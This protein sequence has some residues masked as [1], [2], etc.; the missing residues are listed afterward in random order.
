MERD[1]SRPPTRTISHDG[2][3]TLS[4]TATDA[5]GH[6]SPVATHSFVVAATTPKLTYNVV[7]TDDVVNLSEAANAA[8]VLLTGGSTGLAVGAK[9]NVKL[10][11][12]ATSDDLMAVVAAGGAWT[13]TLSSAQAKAL[14]DGLATLTATAT[15]A[16]GNVS[17]VATH[18]VRI[19]ETPPS[20]T[21]DTVAGDNSLSADEAKKGFAITGTSK[22]LATGATFAVK[23][24]ENGVTHSYNAVVGAN[25][26]WSTNV[27]SA[28]ARALTQ[29][30]AAITAQ[31]M[32]IYGNMSA[33]AMRSISISGG[34]A[35]GDVHL[36][37]F[38]G[39]KYDFQATGE[40][41]LVASTNPLR[42]FEVQVQEL[43]WGNL[44]SVTTEVGVR[45][46]DDALVFHL[47]GSVSIDGLS[48]AQSGQLAGGPI[49]SCRRA[50]TKSIGARASG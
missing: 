4:A 30:S 49:R 40:F 36:T 50:N 39:V 22:G 31:A 35:A 24:A 21:I 11:D 47:D 6:V 26:A 45:I 44:A 20:L 23:V 16:N 5:Y 1:P 8:G 2:P 19:A 28:D 37:S 10:T 3:A 27:P 25:G 15:D 34:Q 29:G 13:A 7:A 46:G 41:V 17:P 43:A 38:E 42:P 12:G 33:L 9:F 48:G 32:D 14:A 18:S